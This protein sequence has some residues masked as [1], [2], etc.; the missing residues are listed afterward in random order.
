[1]PE[2]VDNLQDFR[3]GIALLALI[4]FVAYLVPVG[5]LLWTAATGEAGA[6]PDAVGVIRFVVV[7]VALAGAAITGLG[8]LRTGELT[9]SRRLGR[10]T[11]LFLVAAAVL[12]IVSGMIGDWLA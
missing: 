8:V 11:G 9:R 7:G 10:L 6:T 4:L 2:K 1:M 12:L 3:R 5:Y